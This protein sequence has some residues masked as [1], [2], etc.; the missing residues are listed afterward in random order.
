MCTITFFIFLTTFSRQQTADFGPRTALKVVDQLRE[1]IKGGRLKS[2]LEIRT[3]LKAS[4]VG[5]LKQ[6]GSSDLVLPDSKPAVIL[7][8]GVNG[9]GK[10]TTIGKLSHQLVSGGASVRSLEAFQNIVNC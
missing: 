6:C 5:L 1:E 3:Q 4:I 9:G 2:G 7:I 10:T 8:V